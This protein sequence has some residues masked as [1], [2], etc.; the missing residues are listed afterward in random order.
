MIKAVI[1]DWGGV[2]IDKP[3]KGI[4]E[5]C[6]KQFGVSKD[7]FIEALNPFMPLFN[8]GKINEDVLWSK[9]GIA[10]KKHPPKTNSLWGDAFR[11]IYIPKEE[12]WDLVK[13][14]KKN[15]YKAG[16]LSNT[17]LASV[18]YFKEKG[19]PKLFDATIFSCVEGFSK[20]APEIYK[21]AL[22]KLAIKPE[23]AIFIDDR[24]DYIEGAKVVGLRTILFHSPQQVKEELK[25]H[26]VKIY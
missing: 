23:E 25:N 24:E 16:F 5:Y 13:T 1:F 2:L 21:I 22:K 14:V 19:Y 26:G 17:E 12:M 18:E 3:G 7:A 15:G 10:L 4:R 20:P 9:I 8:S 11:D 6:A